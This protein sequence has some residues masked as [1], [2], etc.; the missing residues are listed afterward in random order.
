MRVRMH[1]SIDELDKYVAFFIQVQAHTS[2]IPPSKGKSKETVKKPPEPKASPGS[3]RPSCSS[4]E[5][6]PKRGGKRQKRNVEDGRDKE[7]KTV[8]GQRARNTKRRSATSKVSY[9]EESSD[10][11]VLSDGEEFKPSSE[12]DSGDSECGAKRSSRNPKPKG[13]G[14]KQAP[15]CNSKIKKRTEEEEYEVEDEEEEEEEEGEEGD[16]EEEEAELKK[17]KQRWRRWQI[18][19][20]DEWIE[21]YLKG[22]KKWTCVDVDEGVGQPELC[23]SQAT[24]PITYVVGVD[25]DGYLK[26]VSSRYDPTWLTSSRKRRI[27]SEWWEETLR[28]YEC[29]DT[30]L[31]QEEDK[32]VKGD[33]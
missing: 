3:K 12:D 9:K 11:E 18:K 14:K 20:E 6:Q 1:F 7:E 33:N 29:P 15:R 17:K 16:E 27:N 2:R 30:K 28:F 10:E 21:V 25:D 24:Q 31:N 19:G 22:P 4:T 32:E 23:S 26:D 5:R 8:E 13:K